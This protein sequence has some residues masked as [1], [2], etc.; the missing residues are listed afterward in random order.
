M[1]DAMGPSAGEVV[2]L[3]ESAVLKRS[4]LDWNAWFFSRH[5]VR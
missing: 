1:N 3:N 5:V 2:A 4:R